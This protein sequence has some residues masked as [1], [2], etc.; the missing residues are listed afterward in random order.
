MNKKKLAWQLP[1][2]AILIIG[3]III[4]KKQAPFRTDEGFV[5]G[6]VYKITYQSEDNL[7]EEIETELKKVDYSLSPF[8]PNSVIT[9]VNHNEKTEV[10]S[11]FVHVFHLAKKISDETHGAFDITVAPLVNAWGFGF[12]KSTGVDSLIVDS[13]RPMIGYQKIDLQ[14]NRINKKRPSY[15]AGLQRYRQGI[16][17]RCSSKAIRT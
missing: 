17:S 6:T 12:K 2:L 3:T 5:F 16:R 14:N 15:N 13:L 4:L 8:N 7:K 1:F 11:F 10:D 9:R